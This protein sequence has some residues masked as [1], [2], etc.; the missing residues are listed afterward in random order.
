MKKFGNQKIEQG[1]RNKENRKQAG[2]T[3]SAQL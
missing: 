1:K 3:I 2:G